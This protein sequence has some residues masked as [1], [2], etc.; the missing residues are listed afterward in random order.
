MRT[1]R[2]VALAALII[3]AASVFTV[4]RRDMADAHA[5]LVGRSQTV[6]T[7]FGTM[8]YAVLGEGM[9]MLTIHGAGG[10]F[11]QGLDLT[12]AMS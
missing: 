7:S 9:P 8:E 6:E 12:S 5:R 1:N 10:G 4:F 11:D 2:F 3:A